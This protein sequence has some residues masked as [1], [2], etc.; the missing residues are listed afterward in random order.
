MSSCYLHW[1]S[2]WFVWQRKS[3]KKIQHYPGN[4]IFNFNKKLSSE[5][6]QN[7]CLT[8]MIFIRPGSSVSLLHNSLNPDIQRAWKQY[9]NGHNLSH[10]LVT[11]INK[12]E[13]W[14]YSLCLFMTQFSH[15]SINQH[16]IL[17]LLKL[18]LTKAIILRSNNF[19]VLCKLL[20]C[21]YI[22]YLILQV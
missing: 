12:A 21:D 10:S 22:V 1:L 17:C 2:D 7:V 9:S 19:F 14:S 6:Y 16:K 11:F 8:V 18:C 20:Y 4:R 13:W 3:S 15:T 5:K